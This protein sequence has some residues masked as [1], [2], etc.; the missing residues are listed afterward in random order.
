MAVFNQSKKTQLLSDTMSEKR[1]KRDCGKDKSLG[2]PG[3]LPE[4]CLATY[5]DV[6][7]ATEYP[8]GGEV[9]SVEAVKDELKQLFFKSDTYSQCDRGQKC[10]S[11]NL[12]M[13]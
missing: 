3:P 8:T 11:E 10:G 6:F 5:R 12:Q 2:A 13:L 1:S 4:S 7:L 9:A